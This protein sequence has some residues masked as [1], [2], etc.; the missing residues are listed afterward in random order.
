MKTLKINLL[1]F[2]IGTITFGCFALLS[3]NVSA[4]V[5]EISHDYAKFD[6]IDVSS[7]FEVTVYNS[8]D[9]GAVLSIDSALEQYVQMYLKGSTLYID[10]NEKNVPK[11]LK[12]EYSG[13]KGLVPTMKV[14][15][16]TDA[17]KNINLHDDATLTV[18]QAFEGTSVNITAGGSSTIKSLNLS[19]KSVKVDLDKK[20]IA[21]MQIEAEDIGINVAGSSS[22]KL[23]QASTS[24]GITAKGSGETNVS[25]DTGILTVNGDGSSNIEVTGHANSVIVNGAKSSKINLLD[26]EVG[27]AEV[28]LTGNSELIE[29][30]TESLKI[31]L[32]GHSVLKYK[33]S[34]ALDIVQIKTST[35]EHYTE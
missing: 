30:A 11:E 8:T 9:Y 25:G 20:A 5:K 12:K 1:K 4:Q 33:N 24:L 18:N 15:V 17:L 10:F 28:V 34:P 2:I 29:S 16:Y 13:R 32:T 27:K 6:C 26:V 21:T 19:A 35:L 23:T 14:A 7:A 31:D 22:L 3:L